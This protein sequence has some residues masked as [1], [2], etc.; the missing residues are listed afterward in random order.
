[1]KL[2]VW[3]GIDEKGQHLLLSSTNKPN[4]PDYL[5]LNVTTNDDGES[6]LTSIEY[7]RNIA[8]LFSN[9]THHN[10]REYCYPKISDIITKLIISYYEKFPNLSLVNSNKI[11][12]DMYSKFPD[13]PFKEPYNREECSKF[14]LE[15]LN[16]LSTFKKYAIFYEFFLENDKFPNAALYGI[17]EKDGIHR[18]Y[19][20]LVDYN[21]PKNDEDF[22]YYIFTYDGTYEGYEKEAKKQI[23]KI[24][25]DNIKSSNWNN[26]VK[27]N[28][29]ETLDN[30]F[31]SKSEKR[32]FIKNNNLIISELIDEKGNGE[33]LSYTFHYISKV[34]IGAY[35]DLVERF[36]KYT[37]VELHDILLYCGLQASSQDDENELGLICEIE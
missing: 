20:E 6:I 9:L 22:D 21:S 27:A 29:F 28:I 10:I 16:I 5:F 18:L 36:D 15:A 11:Y 14:I 34:K 3:V 13:K 23:L 25:D 26:Q 33:L 1:M 4:H 7:Q 32:H 2:Y 19:F 35:R 24:L 12:Q 30:H 17:Y 31:N 8:Q 37:M